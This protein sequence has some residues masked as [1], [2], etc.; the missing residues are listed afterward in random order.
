[1]SQNDIVTHQTYANKIFL[2]MQT[3]QFFPKKTEAS[4]CITSKGSMTVEAAF[5]YPIFIILMVYFL[6]LFQ[7]L[8]VEIQVEKALQYAGRNIAVCESVGD[9]FAARILVEKSLKEHGIRK[10]YI[11]G[12]LGGIHY[13]WKEL[14]SDYL[15]LIVSYEI[16]MPVRFFQFGDE[17]FHQRVRLHKW[18]GDDEAET[19]KEQVVYVTPTGTVYHLTKSCPYL[20]LTVRKIQGTE[21]ANSRNKSGAKYYPCEKCCNGKSGM[22]AGVYITDYGT[23]YHCSES[24]SKLKRTVYEIPLDQVGERGLCNKCEKNG[25]EGG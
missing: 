17:V 1:M 10:A 21:L 2:S 19:E 13:R 23:R 16:D 4:A 22:T 5:L 14:D 20:D 8:K 24:C 25:G 18:V 6:F 12:G 11:K 3:N 7:M 15:D 9:Q